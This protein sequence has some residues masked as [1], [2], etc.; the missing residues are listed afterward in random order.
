[1]RV[2]QHQDGHVHWTAE[3][4]KGRRKRLNK[5]ALGGG[6]GGHDVQFFGHGAHLLAYF[7]PRSIWADT[8]HALQVQPYIKPTHDRLSN[9][10]SPLVSCVS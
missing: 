4:K 5:G 1:M 3:G 9:P 8:F 2:D 10:L 7:V 6:A